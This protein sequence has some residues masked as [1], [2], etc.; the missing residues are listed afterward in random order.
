VDAQ[1]L[2]SGVA[3]PTCASSDGVPPH[4]MAL[5]R[6]G[7]LLK[8]DEPQLLYVLELIFTKNKETE[9]FYPVD[10]GLFF[11][12]YLSYS[13]EIYYVVILLAQ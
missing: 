9:I 2:P 5:N 1:H 13:R 7:P 4:S 10:L 12:Y 3:N 11:S 6:Y 8:R